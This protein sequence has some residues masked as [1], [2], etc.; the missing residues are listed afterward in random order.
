[1]RKPGEIWGYDR[2]LNNAALWDSTVGN[3]QI[4]SEKI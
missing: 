3:R 2:R 4:D 1:M